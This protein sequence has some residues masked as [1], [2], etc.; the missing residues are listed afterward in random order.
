MAATAISSP[1][2]IS[3]MARATPEASITVSDPAK[4]EEGEEDV[5][6]GLSEGV[7]VFTLGFAS[8]IKVRVVG[9]ALGAKVGGTHPT[10]MFK[11]SPGSCGLK[12]EDGS[13][14]VTFA[15]WSEVS[16]KLSQELSW[17]LYKYNI[18]KEK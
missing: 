1:T 8:G 7:A 12:Q 18:N 14:L 6:T 3:E 13:Q 2:A 4:Q 16:T 17:N 10:E 9:T 15:I 11:F 5:L